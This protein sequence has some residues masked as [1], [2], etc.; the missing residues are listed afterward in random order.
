[1]VKKRTIRKL[2]RQSPN[3]MGLNRKNR[4]NKITPRE[5]F[6]STCTAPSTSITSFINKDIFK[7]PFFTEWGDIFNT[8]SVEDMIH[9]T[10]N[11]MKK[12]LRETERS[13]KNVDTSHPGS[14]FSRSVYRT[15]STGFGKPQHEVISQETVTNVDDKGQKYVEKWR[16][17]EK[18]NFRRTSHAKLIDD[19]GIKEMRSHNFDT[20]EEYMHTDYKRLNDKDL[21]SFN[22]EFDTGIRRVRNTLLSPRALPSLLDKPLTSMLDPFY[23]HI[24]HD[25]YL[26]RDLGFGTKRNELGNGTSRRPLSAGTDTSSSKKKDI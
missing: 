23:S 21:N 7:D 1:M 11:K 8:P 22:N 2:I 10:Q 26:D 14:Y 16:A 17:H 12:D 9:K 15:N 19:K 4:I 25:H 6:G 24:G 5:R 3:E 13:T 18:D 20:G